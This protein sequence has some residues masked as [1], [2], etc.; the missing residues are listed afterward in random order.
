MFQEHYLGNKKPAFLTCN[1]EQV[2]AAILWSSKN[3]DLFQNRQ[4]CYG[5]ILENIRNFLD[6][7]SVKLVM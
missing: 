7:V 4:I 6:M 3:N 2:Y 5:R 1:P